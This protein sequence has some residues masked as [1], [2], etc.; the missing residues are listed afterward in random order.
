[1]VNNKA[2]KNIQKGNNRLSVKWCWEYWTDM[3]KNEIGPLSYPH[4]RNQLKVD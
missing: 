2:A 3:Q 1:M 4:R